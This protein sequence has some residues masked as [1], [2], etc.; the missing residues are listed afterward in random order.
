MLDYFAEYSLRLLLYNQPLGGSTIFLPFLF[1]SRDKKLLLCDLLADIKFCF[2]RITTSTSK[3]ILK[4]LKFEK[5]EKK[6]IE[7]FLYV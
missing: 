4:F 7:H 6:K 1:R 5:R 2:V 3:P